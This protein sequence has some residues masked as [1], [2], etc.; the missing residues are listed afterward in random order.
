MTSAYFH[1]KK[2]SAAVR[3]SLRG[4]YCAPGL[5]KRTSFFC[6]IRFKKTNQLL[7]LGVLSFNY[8]KFKYDLSMML[9]TKDKKI[10]GDTVVFKEIYVCTKK[11]KFVLKI[12][13]II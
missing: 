12:Y 9:N 7:S 2:V 1:A 8:S 6:Q 11:T 13:F 4:P 5:V 10:N 3:D